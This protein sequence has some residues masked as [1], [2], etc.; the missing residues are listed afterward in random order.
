VKLAV[1]QS[2]KVLI[3]NNLSIRLLSGGQGKTASNAQLLI[4][5]HDPK[6]LTPLFIGL[7]TVPMD[8]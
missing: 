1:L 4:V 2:K 3:G 5:C 6:K 8:K 7:T